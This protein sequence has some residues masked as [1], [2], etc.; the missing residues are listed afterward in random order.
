MALVEPNRI[1]GDKYFVPREVYPM[2]HYPPYARGMAYVLSEDL[3]SPLGTALRDGVVDPF[4]YRED[5]SVGLYLLELARKGQVRVVPRQRKD[6]M[7]LDFNE[8]CA[9]RGTEPLLVLHRFRL[10]DA[11]CLWGLVEDRRAA[12]R[13]AAS[14]G[15]G[16][17]GQVNWR[18]DFCTCLRS[19]A[20]M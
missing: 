8:Y 5:V 3:V 10:K 7:P 6:M 19:G 9:E 12:A 13:A 20:G 1:E 16:V 4:P 17:T 15:Y 18:I 2:E 14:S 11:P